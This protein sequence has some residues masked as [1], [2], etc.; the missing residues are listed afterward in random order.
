[1]TGALMIG[2]DIGTTG[3]R[4]VLVDTLGEIHA[5]NE[6][7]YPLLTPRPGWAEQRPQDW[8]NAAFESLKAV[9]AKADRPDDVCA[10]GLTGQMHGLVLVDRSLRPL[11]P[12]II[13]CD[14]RT[15]VQRRDLEAKLGV[16]ALVGYTGNLLV[17]GFQAPKL[18]WVREHE[19]HLLARTAY[20]LLPKDFIRLRLTGELWTDVSDA[21]GTGYFDPERRAW[22]QPML[23][24]LE[25]DT[26][27]LPG[28]CES[29][30][31]A[32]RLTT[33]AAERIGLPAGLPVA[34][35]AGDQPAGGVAS[36]IISDGNV[37]ITI[38]SSGVVFVATQAYPS[39]LDGR[40]Q[41]GA[42]VLPET[43][44]LMGVTQSAGL[45]L[46]WFRDTFAPD[47]SYTELIDE[48][49][50]SPPGSRGLLWLPHLQGE[51]TPH[52][53]ADARGAIVGL[54]SAHERSDI[55]RAVLE[56]VA[57]SLRDAA[58]VIGD[59]GIP[60]TDFTLAGGG[61]RSLLWCQLVAATFDASMKIEPEGRGP[62][63][64]AA[65]LAATAGGVFGSVEEACHA[66]EISRVTVEPD[67]V[68]A[69]VMENTRGRYRDLYPSLLHVN[70]KAAEA[71]L[72]GCDP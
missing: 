3:A 42:H 38:G 7:S 31:V 68:L 72:G 65:L 14:L 23:D 60:M 63:F 32:G 5:V 9:A 13:W 47:S 51:R 67:R 59:N 10:I 43:W 54:T 6:S 17:E 1:M 46:R 19:S 39:A 15:A 49:A 58:D 52:L 27:W 40:A 57:F 21:S 29:A 55:T 56:G 18:A 45:S 30:A 50:E 44:N 34:A 16:S 53:D 20:V 11:R 2:L 33:S 71:Q 12:A 62:A 24:E 41:C 4:A 37:V 8:E 61:S 22:S 36:G 70:Q 35:G 64:G 26:A 28:V 66:T 69:R 48:A 25:I